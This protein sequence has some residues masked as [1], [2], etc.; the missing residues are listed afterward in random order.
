MENFLTINKLPQT[1]KSSLDLLSDII[2]STNN[3]EL[4]LKVGAI[5]G[6]YSVYERTGDV[7]I[8]EQIVIDIVDLFSEVTIFTHTTD[9]SIPMGKPNL[10]YA[11][12]Q[13]QDE[14]TIPVESLIEDY[15]SKIKSDS[16]R[17]CYLSSL[18]KLIKQMRIFEVDKSKI[19]ELGLEILS[20]L[21]SHEDFNHNV[22]SA[23]SGFAKHLIELKQI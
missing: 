15:L 22:K 8:L 2:R 21:E 3:A 1:P 6:A 9:Y 18:K 11:K 17:G 14:N 7:S 4:L 20:Y 13:K 16:T 12:T 10:I 19:R 5:K 23:G